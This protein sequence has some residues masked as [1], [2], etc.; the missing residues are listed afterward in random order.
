MS[1]NKNTREIGSIFHELGKEVEQEIEADRLN[2][3]SIEA[4]KLE[5]V[6]KEILRLERDMTMPGRAVQDSTRIERLSKFID[7]ADF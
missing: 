2:Q 3:L 7:E 1:S 4:R 5:Q 6:A